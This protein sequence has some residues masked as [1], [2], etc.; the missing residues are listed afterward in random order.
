MKTWITSLALASLGLSYSGHAQVHVEANIGQYNT[1]MQQYSVD[2]LRVQDRDTGF[3]IQMGYAID[4][5][6]TL[7]L[8]YVN[9]G[10]GY[11][12]LWTDTLNPS[13]YHQQVASVAPVLAEGYT[14]GAEYALLTDETW[15]F[16]T[17]FGL[18]RWHADIESQMIGQTT[19]RTTLND[20]DLYGGFKARYAISEHWDIHVGVRHYQ[21]QTHVN[22]ISLGITRYFGN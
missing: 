2:T 5:R 20:F 9:Q 13:A 15:Q 7:T 3:N 10:E 1:A 4:D 17:E 16:T 22:S 11:A 18:F 14:V 6:A 21:M 8:G 12:V 19:Q